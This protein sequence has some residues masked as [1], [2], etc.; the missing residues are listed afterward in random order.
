MPYNQFDHT[1]WPSEEAWR[2][3]PLYRGDSRGCE[4][5]W[6][7]TD[8]D[9]VSLKNW[10]ASGN[11]AAI[12]VDASKLSNG[13]WSFLTSND[14]LTLDN[15]QNPQVNHENTIVGYNDNIEYTENGTIHHGAFKIANSWGIGW[16]LNPWEH[17]PDGC[18][19]I[20]YEAMKQR[21][22]LPCEFYYDRIGY[23][24]EL[25]ASFRITHSKRGEC[26]ISISTG[27]QEKNFSQYIRGGNQPFCPNTILFDVTEFKD[28]VPD[29]YGHRFC[30]SVRWGQSYNWSHNNIRNQ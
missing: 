20:S 1:S 8:A 7:K 2:E 17:V 5:M 23:Q 24:P 6:V 21:V 29:I 12:G 19:W 25:L 4:Y 30:L 3:A 11:L 18:Y 14:M 22:L 27:S 26:S 9:I 15:Y 16:L 13:L 28:A 10:I